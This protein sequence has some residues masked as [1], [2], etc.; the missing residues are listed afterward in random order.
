MKKLNFLQFAEKDGNVVH[1]SDVENGIDCNCRCLSCG[2]KLIAKNKTTNTKTPH[3]AHWNVKEC[4]FAFET[5]IHKVAKKIINE[6]K[7]ILLP[8]IYN[9]NFEA[10]TEDQMIS[11]DEVISEDEK[12]TSI[13]LNRDGS[14]IRPD[15]I[16]IKN[17]RQIVIEIA[18]THKTDDDKVNKLINHKI[19]A[20]EID[21]ECLSRNATIDEIERAIL[22]PDNIVWLYNDRI[23]QLQNKKFAD[24]VKHGLLLIP[25]DRVN[26]E[27]S[28]WTSPGT[29]F[30]LKCANH[31]NEF[32]TFSKSLYFNNEVVQNILIK[33]N[34][35][36]TIY[37]NPFYE[38]YIYLNQ[39]MIYLSSD[40]L[41]A[42]QELQKVNE[43]KTIIE[44]QE[45]IFHKGVFSNFALCGKD[46]TD[47]N[48]ELS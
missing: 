35:N 25:I 23:E 34:W 30:F 26:Y 13:G 45:C 15:L 1:I 27:E 2:Q 38:R 46:Q 4:A 33:N 12:I 7:Q 17:N 29:N 28:Q 9:S 44:C 31:T 36:H 40:D 42:L 47:K 8:A 16:G 24:L 18:V 39:E 21:L 3:F 11:L 14:F 19:S 10:L 6:K 37:G 43:Y 5:T 20:I 41:K 32:Y 48:K 22:D